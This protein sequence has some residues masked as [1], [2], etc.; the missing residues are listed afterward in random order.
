M[1]T[2]ASTTEQRQSPSQQ[3]EPIPIQPLAFNAVPMDMEWYQDDFLT[4]P[5]VPPAP[6]NPCN[7]ID[8]F[9][10]SMAVD[11]SQLI[12]SSVVSLNEMPMGLCNLDL[13]ATD[14][15]LTGSSTSRLSTE[16]QNRQSW[17]GSFEVSE[18]KTD[19]MVRETQAVIAQVI[20]RRLEDNDLFGEADPRSRVESLA[21]SLF[22]HL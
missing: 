8:A 5:D 9:L 10:A 1:I 6:I 3:Q 16:L 14:S 4:I 7:T 20:G 19:Q 17:R 2:A 12:S 21:S 22:H 13:T 15:P 18:S 11:P